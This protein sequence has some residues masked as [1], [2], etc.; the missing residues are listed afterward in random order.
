M[1]EELDYASVPDRVWWA[2]SFR[3]FVVRGAAAGVGV[4]CAYFGLRA[5]AYKWFGI[6][7]SADHP[8]LLTAGLAAIPIIC[9]AASIVCAIY[10]RG[11]DRFFNA[12]FALVALKPAAF[13]IAILYVMRR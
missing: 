9:S 8:V 1:P 12:L 11:S 2:S 5:A 6:D 4:L 13:A 7:W 10:S 3:S